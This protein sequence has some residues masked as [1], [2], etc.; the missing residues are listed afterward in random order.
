MHK[1]WFVL[2]KEK[3]FLM[4][5]QHEAPGPGRGGVLWAAGGRE[6]G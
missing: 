5:E 6:M 1:L 4:A 3:N 2:L